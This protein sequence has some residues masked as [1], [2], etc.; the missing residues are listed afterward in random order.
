MIQQHLKDWK[1]I[2]LCYQILYSFCYKKNHLLVQKHNTPVFFVSSQT[3][4]GIKSYFFDEKKHKRE[5]QL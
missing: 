3:E 2:H 1:I 5:T 4:H